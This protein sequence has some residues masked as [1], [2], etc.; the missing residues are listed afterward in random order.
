MVRRNR[1][2]AYVDPSACPICGGG[3]QCAKAMGESGPCWCRQETFSFEILARAGTGKACVCVACL[4]KYTR[5]RD[6]DFVPFP[7]EEPPR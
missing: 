4:R 2:A 5:Q 3:N 6:A 7:P 1:P